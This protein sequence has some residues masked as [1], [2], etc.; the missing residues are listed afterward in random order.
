MTIYIGGI[1]ADIGGQPKGV[2]YR[3]EPS[4]EYDGRLD[5][6]MYGASTGH[7]YTRASLKPAKVRELRDAF[8]EWLDQQEG[9]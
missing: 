8:N 9:N 2:E 1:N 4:E 5:V 6:G 7:E 3:I